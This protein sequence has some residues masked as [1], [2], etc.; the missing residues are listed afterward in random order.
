[1]GRLSP[2]RVKNLMPELG[3]LSD[4]LER[5]REVIINSRSTAGRFG[6]VEVSL[7]WQKECRAQSGQAVSI[8]R[9][10][11]GEGLLWLRYSCIIQLLV[12]AWSTCSCRA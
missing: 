5:F 7:K 2:E 4:C 3:S 10:L 8:R 1:M 6:G 9:Q 12:K 11:S